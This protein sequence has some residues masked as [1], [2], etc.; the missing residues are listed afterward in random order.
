MCVKNECTHV[1]IKL[2]LSQKCVC[3]CKWVNK[4]VSTT[5]Y[6]KYRAISK[7]ETFVKIEERVKLENFTYTHTHNQNKCFSN[8]N[9]TLT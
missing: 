4:G 2:L 1:C 5:N 6:Y 9:W 3:V 7:F 8:L